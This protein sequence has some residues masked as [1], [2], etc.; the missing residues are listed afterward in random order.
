MS[1][2]SVLVPSPGAT[3]WLFIVILFLDFHIAHAVIE[4]RKHS[5]SESFMWSFLNVTVGALINPIN[6]SGHSL[7]VDPYLHFVVI[8]YS[9]R[10][11]TSEHWKVGA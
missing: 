11:L 1:S 9:S 7:S 2:F 8:R 5:L 6:M 10:A 3:S 4:I